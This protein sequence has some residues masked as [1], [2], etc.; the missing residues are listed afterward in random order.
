MYAPTI[1]KK[2]TDISTLRWNSP[3]PVGNDCF[4]DDLHLKWGNLGQ[5]Y[6]EPLCLLESK[7]I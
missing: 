5:P 6:K 1:I 3:S 4:T 7:L 2:M